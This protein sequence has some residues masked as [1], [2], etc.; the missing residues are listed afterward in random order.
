MISMKRE[1]E[2]EGDKD[3]RAREGGWGD[4]VREGGKNEK[5]V[6]REIWRER[7]ESER[8]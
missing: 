7:V 6:V 8:S 2:R 1:K 4:I 3:E 5:H